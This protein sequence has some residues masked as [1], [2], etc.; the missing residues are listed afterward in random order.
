MSSLKYVSK[1]ITHNGNF[2]LLGYE[3]VCPSMTSMDTASLITLN[4]IRRVW[5]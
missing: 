4:V 1:A 5:P 2:N 3:E